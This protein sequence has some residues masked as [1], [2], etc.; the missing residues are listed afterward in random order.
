MS[1]I[2]C[3]GDESAP[4]EFKS[5]ELCTEQFLEEFDMKPYEGEEIGCKF[6]I[7]LYQYNDIFFAVLNSHCHDLAPFTIYD[8]NGE[9][10]CFTSIGPCH[11]LESIDHGVIGI[12]Q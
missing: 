4:L 9:E 5:I 11:L 6:H 3:E 2:V 7:R 1:C 8:C 10:F 12:E